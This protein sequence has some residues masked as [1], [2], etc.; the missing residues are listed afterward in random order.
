MKALRGCRVSDFEALVVIGIQRVQG[1]GVIA[2]HIKQIDRLVGCEEQFLA[3]YVF[4]KADS[5]LQVFVFLLGY[6]IVVNGIAFQHILL[7]DI[8]RPYPEL[9]C[10]DRVHAVSDGDELG[11]SMENYLNN[12]ADSVNY[13]LDKVDYVTEKLPSAMDDFHSASK[14]IDDMSD[15][16]RKLLGDLNVYERVS[17]SE[18]D[19]K[20]LR[21]DLDTISRNNSEIAEKIRSISG[22]DIIIPVSGNISYNEVKEKLERMEEDISE[23]ADTVPMASEI[24]VSA[25][26]VSNT[27]RPYLRSSLESVPGNTKKVTGNLSD[28]VS[29]L[30]S[31]IKGVREML[32][33][34]DEFIVCVLCFVGR[35]EEY[36]EL[37][38]L[39]V[40]NHV[41]ENM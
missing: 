22:D 35:V 17:A 14:R 10:P 21:S 33:A 18:N 28:A 31:G 12:T 25:N 11:K 20:K 13:M 37:Y 5:F 19:I 16:I 41:W 24:I 4:K 38:E 34:D 30:K 8:R 36:C 26:E 1:I 15:S 23:L 2:N 32:K 3:E 9:G 27:V 29:S 39:L 6:G 40:T 7:D